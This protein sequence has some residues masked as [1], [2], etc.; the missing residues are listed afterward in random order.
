MN[1]E[2]NLSNWA[3]IMDVVVSGSHELSKKRKGGEEIEDLPKAKREALRA[4][5]ADKSEDKGVKMAVVQTYTNKSYP[6]QSNAIKMKRINERSERF[7]SHWSCHFDEVLSLIN[8]RVKHEE[9]LNELFLDIMAL[10]QERKDSEIAMEL[11]KRERSLNA[12]KQGITS[13]STT[14]IGDDSD[15]EGQDEDK[16]SLDGDMS[17]ESS[18]DDDGTASPPKSHP[19]MEKINSNGFVSN[20]ENSADKSAHRTRHMAKFFKKLWR[21]SCSKNVSEDDIAHRFVDSI[22]LYLLEHGSVSDMSRSNDTGEENLGTSSNDSDLA[23]FMTQEEKRLKEVENME[24]DESS[25][26]EKEEKEIEEV[27]DIDNASEASYSSDSEIMRRVMKESEE[28]AAQKRKNDEEGEAEIQM[29]LRASLAESMQRSGDKNDSNGLQSSEE[30]EEFEDEHGEK[31]QA[32]PLIMAKKDPSLPSSHVGETIEVKFAKAERSSSTAKRWTDREDQLLLDTIEAAMKRTPTHISWKYVLPVFPSRTQ[33][34]LT[35]RYRMLKDKGRAPFDTRIPRLSRLELSGDRTSPRFPIEEDDEEEAPTRTPVRMQSSSLVERRPHP[36]TSAPRS[37]SVD[38]I[39]TTTR[40]T[41]TIAQIS[42]DA[43][44]KHA[45][46]TPS[47]SATAAALQPTGLV[48]TPNSKISSHPVLSSSSSLSSSSLSSVSNTPTPSSS[49]VP[50][51][52]SSSTTLVLSSSSPSQSSVN[53]DTSTSPMIAYLQ[54]VVS[55]STSWGSSTSS[56]SGPVTSPEAVR[57]VINAVV[58]ESAHAQLIG[59]EWDYIF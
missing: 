44:P 25:A 3:S 51:S 35:Q 34:A 13:S 22:Q 32:T 53:L 4:L 39:T 48:V 31:A 37:S 11:E 28:E 17:S 42:S 14:I 49:L 41:S 36:E 8:N 9:R 21:I 18:S 59:H 56:S 45:A 52:L 29:A 58:A 12:K 30:Q 7:L 6:N 47:K 15:L 40:N 50:S 20:G 19:D 5:D 46:T 57:K 55:S 10:E 1:P 54:T 23:L 2:R 27:A 16:S 33:Q 24:M 38:S 43:Q 26:A